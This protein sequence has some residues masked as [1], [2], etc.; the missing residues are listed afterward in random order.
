[1]VLWAMLALT[2]TTTAQEQKQQAS[3]NKVLTYLKNLK[4]FE[5]LDVGV[6][7]G[8]TGV[9]FDVATN[10]GEHAQ[11][12]TGFAFMPH[13]HQDLHFT[14]ETDNL[15]STGTTMK[16]K[17]AQISEK[18]KNFTYY[19]VDDEV[20][21]RGIPTYWNFKLLLDVFPFRNK[22]WHLTA[23]FHWGR[24]QIGKA[25]NIVEDAP[26]LVAVGIYNNLY[27]QIAVGEF[28]PFEFI[29]GEELSW[30]AQWTLRE[31]FQR[32][33]RMGV[34]IG[35]YKEDITDEEGNVIHE[36]GAPYMMVPDADG[37]ARAKMKANAFKPYLGFGYGGR[38]L[39]NDDRYQVSF[40]CGMQFWGGSP[41]VYTHDG[42]N[43]TK[44]VEDIGGKVGDYVDMAK[45]FKVFPVLNVRITKRIF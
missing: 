43:L 41:D 29:D 34:H 16:E 15:E 10:I 23:G 20:T 27:D 9:G 5:H 40:D 13:F 4:G 45:K 3:P 35:N 21:M 26:T 18:M 2:A 19:N 33:G 14:V 36:K 39:K 22:H 17:L 38:L 37:T 32:Y 8:T 31:K 42:T 7:A 24:T 44:D 25:V 6:T 28:Q 12:R 11:L 1:M 30:T